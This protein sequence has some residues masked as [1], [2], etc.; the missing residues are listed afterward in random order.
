SGG[1][2][3]GLRHGVGLAY[4]APAY[5]GEGVNVAAARRVREAVDVPV[6]V[7]GR[8][9]DLRRA[10]RAL[11]EGA[12]DMIGLTRALI[13][14]PR[15]VAKA[16]R[17]DFGAI[18]PCIGG[19]E[20]HYGRQVTCAVNPAAGR[21]DELEIR[22]SLSPTGVLVVGGGPAGM[23]CARVAVQRGHRVT[24]VDENDRLGGT[25][26][27][28]A[29][30][31]NRAEFA[32]YVASM[33]RQLADL[34]VAVELGRRLSADDAVARRPAVIVI[35]TGAGEHLP[36]VPGADPSS[37]VTALQ[38]LRGERPIG[39]RVVVVGGLDDHLPPLTVSDY[40]AEQGRAVTLLAETD[41][42]G[43]GIELASRFALI[44]RLLEKGVVLERLTALRSIGPGWIEVRNTFTNQRRRIDGVDTVVA[45]CGRRSRT[46]L[47][48]ELRGRVPALH[49]IGDSLAPRRMVNATLDGARIAAA[50]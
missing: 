33:T 12:A 5:A 3:T 49:V 24:L 40:L 4:V 38:V 26:A 30:D 11:E 17:G 25:L 27:V 6:M 44:R 2:Y 9:T 19:N 23:E 48:D 18:T 8:F 22:R 14:D 41:G 7:A 42:I 50:I 37:V 28:L 31:S 20:C 46:E 15:I 21:E 45:S 43:V 32:G 29:M 36:D 35:A 1:N 47:A 34:G 10:A 16:R 13:A 39:Q